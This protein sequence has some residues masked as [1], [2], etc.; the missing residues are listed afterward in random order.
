MAENKPLAPSG[1]QTR[2]D[3]EGF[4][5]IFQSKKVKQRKYMIKCAGCCMGGI[6][7]LAILVTALALSVFRIKVPEVKM[8]RITIPQLLVNGSIPSTINLITEVAFKNPNVAPFKY[9]NGTNFLSYHGNIVG[10][11]HT[12]PGNSKARRTQNMN[13]SIE[14]N[15]TKVLADPNFKSEIGSGLLKMSSYIR[16]RGRVKIIKI[17]KKHAV[18]IINCTI[19]ANITGQ[20]IVD[21]KCKNRVLL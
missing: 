10:E 1:S 20:A 18:V 15:T 14:V 21:Q 11:G 12:P 8:N 4:S 17:I 3:E 5:A 7:L 16:L 19:T 9:N 2:R 13:I 6:L